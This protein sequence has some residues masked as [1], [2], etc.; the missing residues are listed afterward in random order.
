M[1]KIDLNIPSKFSHSR[2]LDING[3]KINI[4]KKDMNYFYSLVYLYRLELLELNPKC[5]STDIVEVDNKKGGTR[6]KKTVIEEKINFDETLSFEFFQ[7][8]NTIRDGE[9]NSKYDSIR[10]FI[11]KFENIYVETN[12]FE[13]DKT[14]GSKI[15]KVFDVLDLGDDNVSMNVKFTTDYILPYIV[16]E[17]YFKKVRLDILH[18]FGSSYAKKMY[19]F[20][21]DYSNF[22]KK[23][24]REK[25]G[26][27]L[28]ENFNKT[29]IEH[30]ISSV[31]KSDI[32]VELGVPKNRKKS[33]IKFIV[34]EQDYFIGE[35][36]KYDH[37]VEQFIMDDCKKITQKRID[38]GGFVED[39]DLYTKSIFDKKFK[40]E[41]EILKYMSM[42]DIKSY[43]E[44]VKNR[45]RP[46]LDPNEKYPIFYIIDDNK[47][48]DGDLGITIN[49]N[50]QLVGFPSFKIIE[51]D[52]VNTLNRIENL[53][54]FNIHYCPKQVTGLSLITFS[55]SER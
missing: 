40:S 4:T 37:D 35:E 47:I 46:T 3:K 5:L 18:R 10:S 52:P 14:E 49:D 41:H 6:K 7:I 9:H 20:L 22:E 27:F 15:M 42:F 53:T 2:F 17:K 45:L 38:D 28:G 48:I 32:K 51:S 36:E 25:I 12:L 44:E 23:T 55:S 50:Y 54:R 16:T 1:N 31:N 29:K 19:L 21:K 13:K 11:K 8:L 26:I 39:F 30:Y 24:N 34:K 43:I 33:E